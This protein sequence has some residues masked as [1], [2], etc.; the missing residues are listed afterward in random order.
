MSILISLL[1]LIILLIL[2]EFGHFIVAKKFRVKVD[3]FGIGYPPRIIGKKI[4][5]TI[6]SLNLI[7]FGAF[8]KMP[9]EIKK[10]GHPRSFSSQPVWKRAVIAFAGVLSFWIMAAI[11]FSIVSVLGTP[12]VIEDAAKEGFVNPRVQIANVVVDSP[13]EKAGLKVGDAIIK[14]KNPAATEE[15][16][17]QK[18][19]EVQEFIEE[20]KGEE[21]LL[22]V[23]RG[24]EI[25]EFFLVPRISPPSGQGPLGVA[26]VRTA[27]K[28]YPWYIAP[29]KGV[30]QT[31]NLTLAVIQGYYQALKNIFQGEPS[32]VQLTGPV[33][34]FKILSD[35]RELGLSY[36]LSLLALI[37]IYLAIFNLL[38]I[39]AVDGGKLVF[40]AIEAIR[41][42][43][44][45]ARI[46]E[47][48]SAAFFVMLIIL[49][50]FI[51]IKDIGRIF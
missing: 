27:T 3:E 12:A 40:L 1:G 33:G 28:H 20:N 38:P 46:E 30:S 44:I 48:V 17:I 34:V 50:I 39:P 16:T 4:G 51:T 21:L 22:I 14:I 31:F 29:W 49:M 6:Y 43:P 10:D 24:K 37:S 42:K 25:L 9:G 19:K 45:P 8:V 32:G 47:N 7:P 11:I 2:H 41:K 5:E 26:L 18:T 35:A 15:Q 23:E 36:F 13:A